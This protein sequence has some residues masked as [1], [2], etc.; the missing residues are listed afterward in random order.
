MKILIV[1]D[2]QS[3]SSSLVKFFKIDDIEK[4]SVN[5]HADDMDDLLRI[6]ELKERLVVCKV[7]IEHLK[8]RKETRWHSFA[9]NLDYPNK[10]DDYLKY[11]NSIQHIR[12][13]RIPKI[14]DEIEKNILD[15]LKKCPTTLQD[16]YSDHGNSIFYRKAGG[17]YYKIIT[18]VAT[19]SS[20]EGELTIKYKYQD[21]V[22]AALSS[23]LFYWF[24]LIH[25]DWHNLRSSELGM[26]PIPYDEFSDE[27]LVY[28]GKLYDSYLDDLY[29]NFCA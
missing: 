12:N 5:L 21:L 25:S 10:N 3:I 18:K 24:W 17:R 4:L 7:L 16:L 13:G 9:E 20:A 14:G 2:E 15:K 8:A 11:V 28:I 27:D 26:F 22:G 23:N 29:K 1:D 19:K 6:Y